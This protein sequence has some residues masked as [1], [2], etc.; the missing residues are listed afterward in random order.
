MSLTFWQTSWGV[1]H[2]KAIENT[3]SLREL[4]SEVVHC[5]FCLYVV[6]QSKSH[7]PSQSQGRNIYQHDQTMASVCIRGGVK[8]WGPS[9]NI[10]QLLSFCGA[11]GNELHAQTSVYSRR[12][13]ARVWPEEVGESFYNI[14]IL[15][16]VSSDAQMLYF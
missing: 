13:Q 15:N 8:T 10:P 12:I 3:Q 2:K 16:K 11:A 14:P 1:I 5:H 4:V 7:G 6:G 9:S